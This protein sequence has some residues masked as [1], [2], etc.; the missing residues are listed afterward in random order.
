VPLGYDVHDR[1]LVGT[2]CSQSDDRQTKRAKS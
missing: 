1:H 2:E